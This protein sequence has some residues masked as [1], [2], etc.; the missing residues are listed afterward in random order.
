LKQLLAGK[1]KTNRKISDMKKL[2]IS[3]VVV[4]VFAS[5]DSGVKVNGAAIDSAGAK[6]QKTVER[7]ADTIA[8]K[9]GRW[10]DSIDRKD[11]TP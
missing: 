6:L 4:L 1:L 10:K 7:G 2:L 11:T 3:G 5:C 8:S 9:V